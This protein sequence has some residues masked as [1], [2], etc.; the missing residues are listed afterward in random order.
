[1]ATDKIHIRHYIL[2]EFQQG[3]NAAKTYGSICSFLGEDVSRYMRI[4]V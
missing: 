2:Y 3:E 1:L 4:L